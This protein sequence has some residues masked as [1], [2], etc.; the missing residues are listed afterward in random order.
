MGLSKM[1]THVSIGTRACTSRSAILK[2]S[3][4]CMHIRKCSLFQLH[5]QGMDNHYHHANHTL[6]DKLRQSLLALSK[7]ISDQRFYH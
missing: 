7:V 3:I 5:H 6:Y 2:V 4:C 1:L